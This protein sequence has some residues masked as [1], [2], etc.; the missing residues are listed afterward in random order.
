MGSFFAEC[1]SVVCAQRHQMDS[2]SNFFRKYILSFLSSTTSPV[3]FVNIFMAL[4]L[5]PVAFLLLDEWKFLSGL[6]APYKIW[7][8]GRE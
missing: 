6:L 8:K 1:V 4:F 2:N 7:L 3:V 5:D